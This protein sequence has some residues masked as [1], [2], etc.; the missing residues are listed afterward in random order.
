LLP[1]TLAL[2][3]ASNWLPAKPASFAGASSDWKLAFAEG[4]VTSSW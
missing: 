1:A 2:L 3:A 4:E